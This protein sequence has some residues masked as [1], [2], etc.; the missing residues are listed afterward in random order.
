MEAAPL[1]RILILGGGFAGLEAARRL[2]GAPAAVTVLDRQNHHLFQPLLYQVAAAT[3]SPEDIA[4]PIRRILHRAPNVEVLLGEAVGVD[5]AARRVRLADGAELPY[6][7]LVMATGAGHS[8]FGHPEWGRVAPGLKDIQD[9]LRIRDLFLSTFEKA[10]REGD[11]EAR[12]ALLTFVIVGGGPTGVELAGTLKEMARL[13]LPRDF[14]RIRTEGARVVLVEAGPRILPAFGEGLPEA[15]LRSL[16]RIGV[17]VLTDSPVT[18][19]D[20]G[21][22]T[23]GETRIPARTVLWA[24]GVA[25]SPLGQSL[26]VA[27]DK[28]GRVPVE[29][30]LSLPGHPEVFVLGDLAAFSH[31]LDRPL[32]GLAA[33]AKQEG[34]FVAEALRATLAGRPRGAFRYRDRGTMATIG[35]GSAVAQWGRLRLAGYGAWLLWL[36]VHLMLLVGFR[37]RV[38][39]FWQWLWA[40]ATAQRR[41]R[42]ILRPGISPEGGPPSPPG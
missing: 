3:L 13:S 31:G 34:R 29:A 27:T 4:M 23:L 21:G 39:V 19:V 1:P 36:F 38:F 25:A 17:E 6:D 12:R 26:G 30:D 8:Y 35:R 5:L 32:P 33:V 14:R 20:A 37:N 40:Y 9:A 11:P 24:A 22:V 42:L 18:G 15:A 16:A 7:H 28:A 41:A 2:A 10:E